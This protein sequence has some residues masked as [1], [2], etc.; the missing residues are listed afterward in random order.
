MSKETNITITCKKCSREFATYIHSSVNVRHDIQ[1]REKI[2]NNKFFE[3]TC[4]KCGFINPILHDVL[5]HDMDNKFMIW[6]NVPDENNSI[7]FEMFALEGATKIL[8]DY[9]LRITTY[10]Y[11]FVEKIH[12]LE[13]RLDDRTMELYK[14]FMKERLR[15]PLKTANDFFHFTGFS[16]GL[17]GK[18]KINYN[19]VEN[20]GNFF[21][22]AYSFNEDVF[23][24]SKN[25]VYSLEESLDNN[26]WYLVDWRFPFGEEIIDGVSNPLID[27][28]EIIEIEIR[29]KL[30][31]LPDHFIKKAVTLRKAKEIN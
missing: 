30:T 16:K 29:G 8:K 18:K 25:L 26:K 17:F 19:Y 2:L 4:P 1:L 28:S 11:F 27:E 5:Y 24:Q 9:T 10:P 22:K 3:L 7:N 20:N 14:F 13:N 23:R 31:K 21:N 12:L 15:Y 6:L